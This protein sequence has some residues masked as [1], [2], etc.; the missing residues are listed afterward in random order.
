M[1][2]ICCLLLMQMLMTTCKSAPDGQRVLIETSLGDITVVLYEDTPLH[3]DNFIKL[4][5]DGYYKDK[6]FHRVIKDFMIQA[7]AT[8]TIKD[9]TL[10]E[11][12]LIDAEFRLP[13]YFHKAG[14]LAA[15]RWGDEENPEK[16]SDA[17]QFYIVGNGPVFD[18]DIR[19]LEKERFETL[20]QQI[21][22]KNQAATMDTIKTM[23]KEGNRAG[24][25]EVRAAN[26][27]KSDKE[28]EDR[29]SEVLFTE[30]QKEIYKSVGGAPH[31][32]GNY[33]VFGEVVDGMDVVK[34][35]EKSETSSNDKPL[36][37]IVIKNMR[38][39]D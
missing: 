18:H 17:F 2:I 5:K 31:L 34:A 23:Y 20:K 27:E 1:R 6:N 13:K 30:E 11:E 19:T 28:A 4:V 36:H 22:Q 21:F 35:I 8:N 10:N 32:D 15:A 7:G 24:I 25:A 39:I 3:R 29:R 33:T 37:P 26:I 14:A 9:S 16:K 38:F 12:A